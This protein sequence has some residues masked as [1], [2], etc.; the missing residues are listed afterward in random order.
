MNAYKNIE[1]YIQ[2]DLKEREVD[3][4]EDSLANDKDLF[5][6]YRL[7]K[8]VEDAL[9]E[10]DDVMEFRNQLQ[11]VMKEKRTNPVIWF[12]RKAI[13]AGVVG[14]LMLSM[15]GVG[16][17]FYQIDH[18]PTTDKIFE[19]YYQPYEATIT[20]RSGTGNEVNSLLTNALEKYKEEEYKSA[21]QLFQQ[22]LQQREDVAASL[23][24]GISYMEIDKY[25][26]ANKSFDSVVEDKDNL[27]LHQAQ[28]YMSMC[29]IK[30]NNKEQALTILEDLSQQSGYYKEKAREVVK[31]LKRISKE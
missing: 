10:D 24:S 12:K 18:A 23:Y 4:F 16:Y 20:F 29:H 5:R 26:K 28:W 13:V 22:V 7:R 6:E 27:F 17:Y 14:A 15:G 8:D 19:E 11:D 21:L 9:R 25:K 31:K 2:G 3:D 1:R 30:L